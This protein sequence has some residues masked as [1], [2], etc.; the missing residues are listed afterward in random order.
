[1][2]W[3]IEMLISLKILINVNKAV[4]LKIV[5][6]GEKYFYSIFLFRENGLKKYSSWNAMSVVLTKFK[7]LL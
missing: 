1:M 4:A 6:L 7:E 5:F 2:L 3:Y